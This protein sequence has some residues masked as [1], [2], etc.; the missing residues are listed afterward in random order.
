MDLSLL[1]LS[2]YEEKAYRTLVHLGK[3]SASVISREG[4]VSY[5]KIYEVLGRLEAKGLVHI[6]PEVTKKFIATNPEN[7][8]ALIRKRREEFDELEK[9]VTELK[10]SYTFHE[11]EAVKIIRGKKNFY[12]IFRNAPKSESFD[13]IVKW[14]AQWNPLFIRENKEVLKKGISLKTL[15]RLDETTVFNLKKWLTIHKNFRVFPNK[16]VAFEVHDNWIL[17]I[18]INQNI[19]MTI[20]DPAFIDLMKTLFEN[21]FESFPLLTEKMIDDYIKEHKLVENRKEKKKKVEM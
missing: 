17:I 5:G 4:E 14:E 15:V 11:T 20:E 12:K 10:Q 3:S 8:L 9:E 18:L 16:G 13:Y 7:L 6:I 21:S 2:E 19:I 1:G